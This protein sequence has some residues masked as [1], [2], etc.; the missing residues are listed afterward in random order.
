MNQIT[1]TI[2]TY[3]N[4]QKEITAVFLFGS[5]AVNKERSFSDIDIGIVADH[6]LVDIVRKNINGYIL[7]LSRILRKDIHITILNTTSEN[8]LF[9][10]FKNGL[11]LVVNNRKE[12]SVF[13]MNG[14]TK[15][16]DF[17]YHK[18]MLQQG[19]LNKIMEHETYG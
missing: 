3:F 15:I 7:D 1:K 9:Q 10:V 6:T 14:Y 4:G 18:R 5:Y 19:F 12:L 8:L 13:K 16:A 11:C 2:S 17:N